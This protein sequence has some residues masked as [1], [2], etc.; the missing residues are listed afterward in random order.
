MKMLNLTIPTKR[1]IMNNFFLYQKKREQKTRN[2]THFDFIEI[3]SGIN[4]K[5][6]MKISFAFIHI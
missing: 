2:T 4:L 1:N 6:E 5:T 3:I